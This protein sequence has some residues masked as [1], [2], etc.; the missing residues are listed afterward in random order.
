MRA[1]A[2]APRTPPIQG[3]SPISLVALPSGIRCGRTTWHRSHFSAPV[4]Q[5]PCGA[6]LDGC[7]HARQP[8]RTCVGCASREFT[9]DLVP[10]RFQA[11]VHQCSNDGNQDIG[12]INPVQ[13][14][15]R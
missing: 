7:M 14:S 6:N 12:S 1:E 13:A 11:L 2:A 10:I 8:A 3:S 15:R 9:A 5:T 4:L